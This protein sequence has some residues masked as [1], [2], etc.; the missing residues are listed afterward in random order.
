[1]RY[2]MQTPRVSTRINDLKTAQIQTAIHRL[3]DAGWPGHQRVSKTES[4]WRQ[5]QFGISGRF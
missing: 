1:M 3:K 5:E 4:L 2:L